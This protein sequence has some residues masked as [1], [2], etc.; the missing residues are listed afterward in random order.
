MWWVCDFVMAEISR[1]IGPLSTTGLPVIHKPVRKLRLQCLI[2]S[3]LNLFMRHGL[4]HLRPEYLKIAKTTSESG[5]S[6]DSA[7]ASLDKQ[8]GHRHVYHNPLGVIPH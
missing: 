7:P 3:F 2:P 4:I 5:A 6:L 1:V 8:K